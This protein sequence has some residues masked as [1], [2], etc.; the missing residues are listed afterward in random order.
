VRKNFATASLLFAWL[1]A[2]GA[3]SDLAQIFAWSRMFT[4]Y[5][6]VLSVREA[7]AV[8][9]DADKPCDLC[10]AV[11]KNRASEESQAGT[12]AL[13][14]EKLLLACAAAASPSI[15]MPP[16]GNWPRPTD[17]KIVARIET[18][19]VRPPRA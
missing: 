16:A 7:L 12:T 3:A 19:P 4:G 9:F 13:S 15:V 14:T 1:C 18:V 8:T 11:K 10:V 2:N 5:A 6:R 17:W